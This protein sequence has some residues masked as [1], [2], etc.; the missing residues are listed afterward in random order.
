[1]NGCI[2]RTA[3]GQCEKFSDKHRNTL[4]WCVGKDECEFRKL[5]NADIIRKMSDEEFEAYV[6]YH[7]AT[8]EKRE[9]LGCSS[10]LLYICRK[11]EC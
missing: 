7:I 4:S 1:M 8:C 10:H 6:R 3:D 11:E 2:Y 9:L 5:S